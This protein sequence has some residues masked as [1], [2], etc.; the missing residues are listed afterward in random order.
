MTVNNTKAYKLIDLYIQRADDTKEDIRDLCAEFVWYESIDSPFVRLDVTI[1]DTV[2]YAESLFGDEMIHIGFNTFASSLGGSDKDRET[3]AYDMQIYKIS[4]VIKDE[5]AKVCTINC[6]SPQAYLNEANRAFGSFGPL[7][8]KHDI[9]KEMCKKYLKCENKIKHVGALEECTSMNMISPNWRPVDVI[10]YISDKVV[11]KKQ[12]KGKASKKKGKKV[13]QSGFLFYETKQGFNWRSIDDLCEQES[14][15]TFSYTQK[16]IG[17]ADPYTQWANIEDLSFPDR[18]NHLEKMRTGLYKT[19]TYG[20]V[21]D[22]MTESAAIN[23]ALSSSGVFDRFQELGNKFT[24]AISG[25]FGSKQLSTEQFSKYLSDSKAA[26]TSTFYGPNG[27]S[28]FDWSKYAANLNFGKSQN[29][30]ALAEKKSKPAGTVQGPRVMHIGEVTDLASTL[31]KGFAFD[32]NLIEKFEKD[33]PT[34]TK[35]R[36]LPKYKNQ[37]AKAANG[38][39]DDAPDN[40]VLAGAYAAARFAL[41]K[42]HVMNITIPGNTALYAGAVIKTKIPESS[43]TRSGRLEL[44]KKFSGRYLVSGLKH[45]YRKEGVTTELYLCRDSLPT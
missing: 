26:G 45:T 5:R 29:Q 44:D 39:A 11:R 2:N 3:L 7:T 37:S 25:Q 40:I 23:P 1:L 6:I 24:A 31:E 21:V 10:S 17:S 12:G 41:L 35:F 4:N 43:E 33:Y 15:A 8:G 9:V 28:K 38:G 22:A 27:D 16:N 42:T 13:I 36:I 32:K 34:R 30:V 18:T 19:V 20:M 14:L